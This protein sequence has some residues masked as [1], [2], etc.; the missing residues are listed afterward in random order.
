MVSNLLSGGIRLVGRRSVVLVTHIAL[1]HHACKNACTC[2]YDIC[3][4]IGQA[5][6]RKAGQ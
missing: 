4:D 3:G 1:L 6:W 2:M 5:E